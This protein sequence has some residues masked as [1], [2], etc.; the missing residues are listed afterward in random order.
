MDNNS[1]K[2][3]FSI[4]DSKTFSVGNLSLKDNVLQVGNTT[5]NL[6]N[7]GT[8]DV[9][10]FAKHSYF[11]GLKKWLGGL[12]VLMIICSIFTN[13]A[14][15]FDL[16]L[17]TLIILIAYN[18]HEHQKTFYSLIIEI[19]SRKTF[20]I[21]SNN[22]QF[23]HDV[24]DIISEAMLNKKSNY[25]INLD[26]HKIINNGIINKGSKNKNKVINKNDK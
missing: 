5:I 23:I 7:I 24:R 18:V 10:T 11:F 21:K 12:I 22:N 17:L 16:Y 9:F 4:D 3:V 1:Y 2:K 6:S 13:L 20:V 8:M 15:I 26:D 25:I 19:H 14:I